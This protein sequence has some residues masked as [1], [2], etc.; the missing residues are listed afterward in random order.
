MTFGIGAPWDLT[1]PGSPTKLNR[2]TI[3]Y[4]T[5]ADITA[6]DKT[7]FQYAFSTTTG[8]GL[9]VDHLYMVNTAQDSFIDISGI[10]SHNHSSVTTGGAIEGIFRNNP[11][12][13]DT[14]SHYLF[15]LNKADWG[16]IVSGTGA[17]TNDLDRTTGNKPEVFYRCHKWQRRRYF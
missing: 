14:G 9:L 2:M 13:I 11:N 10:A 12:F 16:E 1:T 3:I 6:L 4:G 8:S 15:N 17:T 5:A 7:T